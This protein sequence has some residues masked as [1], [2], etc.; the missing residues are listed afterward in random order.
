MR[1]SIA[2]LFALPLAG[3]ERVTASPR[4]ASRACPHRALSGNG[5]GGSA[6]VLLGSGIHV[7][8][9]RARARVERAVEALEH[10]RE[11][12][13][14]AVEHEELLEELVVAALAEPEETV[15]L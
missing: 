5:R 4:G 3:E 15:L 1:R 11:I 14:D 12:A 6:A 8:A 7:P 9:L 10:R 2:R 13:L